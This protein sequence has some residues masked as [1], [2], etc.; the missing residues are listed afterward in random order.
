MTFT[1]DEQTAARI[2][3]T[4][5]RLGIPKSRVVREA[6]REYAA[7]VGRLSEEE[8]VRMLAVFDE[9]VARIP[10]RPDKAVDREIE[11]VRRARK[12]GGR[13]TPPE[14]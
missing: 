3:R 10:D 2:D 4:A 7:R 5:A 13:G 1:L 9:V 8:R 14:R 6:V 11:S 12:R